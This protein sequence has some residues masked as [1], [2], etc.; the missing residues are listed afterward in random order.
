MISVIKIFVVFVVH[1]ILRGGKARQ[2][3]AGIFMPS[4]IIYT[5]TVSYPR[6]ES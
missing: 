1:S 5:Y 3:S 6:V 4:L 2:I